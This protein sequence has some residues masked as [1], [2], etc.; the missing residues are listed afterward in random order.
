MPR[1][2]KN[3]HRN[4]MK[5]K[6]HKYKECHHERDDSQDHK[7]ALN[8]AAVEEKPSCS[9][10]SMP[11]KIPDK[12]LASESKSDTIEWS[13][14]EPSPT[15]ICNDGTRYVKN[16]YC[17]GEEKSFYP[18]YQ[19]CYDNP[20][21]NCLDMC[22]AFVEQ[23]IL[24]KFKMKQPIIRE[25]LLS[26]INPNYQ[27]RYQEIFKRAFEHIEIVF[28]VNVMEVDT[29]IHLYDLVSKI[30]LPNKGRVCAGRGLPKTG[31]L[32]NILAMIFMKGNS[33]AEEEVWKFL[34]IMQVYPG[35]KHFIYREPRK[36]I[37]QDLVKLKY[38][39]YRQIPNS[40]PPRYEF[41]WGP[42]AY[43]EVTKMKVLEFM[44]EG[45]DTEPRKFLVQYAEALREENQKCQEKI[46]ANTGT[47]ARP[48]HL[49]CPQV[50]TPK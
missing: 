49:P 48:R 38:L 43:T 36:L 47:N 15:N 14:R 2:R 26:V 22:V 27:Y 42:K 24:Y 21:R 13:S 39:D 44:A 18:E 50:L 29:T 41:L 32:M 31:L 30:K 20:C 16:E 5:H 6:N 1:S 7:A 3:K 12:P 37:T 34:N 33:V 28:A 4:H 35:R 10:S 46:G 17:H 25:D 19:P 45:S 8:S 23:Y 11:E 9:L 40:D